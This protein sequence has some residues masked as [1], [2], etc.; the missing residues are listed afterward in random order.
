MFGSDFRIVLLGFA[1]V[2]ILWIPPLFGEAR[3]DYKVEMII[4]TQQPLP[5]SQTELWSDRLIQPDVRNA[6]DLRYGSRREGF[7][8]LATGAKDLMGA[9]ARLSASPRYRVIKH[10]VWRQPGL[11][12]ASAKSVRLQGGTDYSMQFP[13]RMRLGN[14]ANPDVSM[15]ESLSDASLFELDGTVK[16]VL[17]R[18][19][20]VYTDLVFRQPLAPS[21]SSEDGTLD[22][23][24]TLENSIELIDFQIK[25]RRRMR[26]RE[27]HYIDHPRLGILIQ[28]TPID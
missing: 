15:G 3:P 6:I 26:S 18:Y 11:D 24:E 27:L 9:N 1:V 7:I 17:G 8:S 16:I 21:S 12:K 13:N 14:A 10:L 4:F 25:N 20:H 28:I 5:G 19:L 2:T 23:D 22:E